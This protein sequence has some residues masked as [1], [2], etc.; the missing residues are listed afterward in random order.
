[1]RNLT[2][3]KKKKDESLS[4]LKVLGKP[5]LCERLIYVL[6]FAVFAYFSPLKEAVFTPRLVKSFLID[7][8]K[9]ES[10]SLRQ[11]LLVTPLTEKLQSISGGYCEPNANIAIFI[12]TRD[13][14]NYELMSDKEGKFSQSITD[15]KL[16][17]GDLVWVSQSKNGKISGLSPS[18]R[19]LDTALLS[20]YLE[21]E[22]LAISSLN[23]IITILLSWSVLIIG[24]LIY[25]T[26]RQSATYRA[27]WLLI[28]IFL[29]FILS[30][31]YGFSCSS[32]II[33]IV[34]KGI[35]VMESTFIHEYWWNQIQLFQQ[36]IFISGLFLLWNLPSSYKKN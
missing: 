22:K 11:P 23:D 15:N 14:P 21:K 19:V 31:Y 20:W 27:K 18:Y 16:K 34:D 3:G 32:E 36:A 17:P 13:S 1:M 29:L 30:I 8:F 10:K 2:L 7:F 24:G 6:I 12:G 28:P 5:R 35:S 26:I 9:S 4:S 25:L 33:S